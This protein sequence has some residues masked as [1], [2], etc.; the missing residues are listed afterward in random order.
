MLSSNRDSIKITKSIC[1]PENSHLYIHLLL[2]NQGWCSWLYPF[3]SPLQTYSLSYFMRWLRMKNVDN[4]IAKFVKK[5]R[6]AEYRILWYWR[7]SID[8]WLFYL[9]KLRLS[10]FIRGYPS[11]PLRTASVDFYFLRVSSWW[12]KT[13]LFK[14]MVRC[15]AP[16]DSWIISQYEDCRGLHRTPYGASGL[17]MT[18]SIN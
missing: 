3:S 9:R 18:T 1:Y 15:I 16:Y 17:A 8:D 2:L 14:E 6:K 10:A 11:A 4:K 5:G 13:A 7:F 12:I